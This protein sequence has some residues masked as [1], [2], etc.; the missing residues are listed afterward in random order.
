MAVVMEIKNLKQDLVTE[1][2]KD[3]VELPMEVGLQDEV[4]IICFIRGLPSNILTK[5]SFFK[6]SVS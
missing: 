3:I 2:K 4:A 1:Q 6:A 5:V